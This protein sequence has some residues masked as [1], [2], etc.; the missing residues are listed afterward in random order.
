MDDRVAALLGDIYPKGLIAA[1]YA[2]VGGIWGVSRGSSFL[3]ELEPHLYRLNY[4]KA[5]TGYG[6][7]G[8]VDTADVAMPWQY[9]VFRVR[10]ESSAVEILAFWK[11]E[12]LAS[13]NDELIVARL[14]D[15]DATGQ[16]CAGTLGRYF[17]GTITQY[18]NDTMK[19]LFSFS[20]GSNLHRGISLPVAY[21]TL[22]EWGKA[23]EEDPYCYLTWT[24]WE[25]DQTKKVWLKPYFGKSEAV[26][27]PKPSAIVAKP[28]IEANDK[29]ED[30][31]K[32]DVG[33][34]RE[35]WKNG[36]GY[37]KIL[38][39]NPYPDGRIKLP[40]HADSGRYNAY[41]E[42]CWMRVADV[43]QPEGESRFYRCLVCLPLGTFENPGVG[44]AY[45][46]G[47]IKLPREKEGGYAGN[48][49]CQEC[50][51]RDASVHLLKEG[52][53]RSH[54]LCLDC[55]PEVVKAVPAN[56]VDEIIPEYGDN[57]LYNPFCNK[58]TKR[59]KGVRIVDMKGYRDYRCLNCVPE[60][61]VKKK[62][63]I[64]EKETKP[65]EGKDFVRI[66][67]VKLKPVEGVDFFRDDKPK[68][69]VDYKVSK[70]KKAK[71]DEEDANA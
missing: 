24:D 43:Y 63:V 14:S 10:D 68:A 70:K 28:K 7:D 27:K 67:D 35:R 42:K 13:L 17:R 33:I 56:L 55:D 3:I 16:F 58:C 20:R 23:S 44:E 30:K 9:W 57:G 12:R 22:A 59:Y 4:A 49:T 19:L 26:A 29:I 32:V 46:N 39:G 21:K 2:T 6:G 36:E 65:V 40:V 48:P 62:P 38:V 45:K 5:G 34:N 8:A 31:P 41:C 54:F 69:G 50:G 25:T 51:H 52:P 64:F 11:K 71:I 60:E 1:N 18:I 47:Q 66:E 61:I 15:T 37:P 53:N